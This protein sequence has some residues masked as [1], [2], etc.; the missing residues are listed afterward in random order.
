MK[1]CWK[2]PLLFVMF[3]L[4][5]S[6]TAA[7]VDLDTDTRLM[8]Y[9]EREAGVLPDVSLMGGVGDEL[10]GFEAAL[11]A[12]LK[13]F[14]QEV[15]AGERQ[16]TEIKLKISE[17]GDYSLVKE[18][19][20]EKL[21]KVHMCL[22]A[23]CP[24]DLYWH[25][26]YHTPVS[27]N[28]VVLSGKVVEM[29]VRFPVSPVYKVSDY[30]VRNDLAEL[31]AT[32][33]ETARGI[34]NAN[35]VKKDYEKLEAYKDAI[36]EMVSYD[37][38][39][40][41]AGEL[42]NAFDGNPDTNIACEGYSKA[43]KYLC[44]L[45]TFR[46]PGFAS[47]LVSGKTSASG[48]HM[49]NHV[50]LGGRN[51]LT[52][53]T[54]CDSNG[55]KNGNYSAYFMAHAL[56]EHN[57]PQ[58]GYTIQRNNPDKP[59]DTYV[60]TDIDYLNMYDKS[61][62]LLTL[63]TAPYALPEENIIASGSC[64]AKGDNVTYALDNLGVLLISGSGDMANYTADSPAPWEEYKGRIGS[65][66][67]ESGVTSIG[68]YAFQGCSAS[69]VNIP[70]SVKR[71]GYVA[72][73]QSSLTAVDMPEGV[74]TIADYAFQ[75]CGYL[76]S[77]KIPK[78]VTSIGKQAFYGDAALQSITIPE[79]VSI[80]SDYAFYKCGSLS[81]VTLPDSVINIGYAAFYDC[82]SLKSVSLPGKLTTISDYAFCKCAG[83]EAVTMPDTIISIGIQAFSGCSCLESIVIPSGV[84]VIQDKT[85]YECVSLTEIT[86]SDSIAGIG[87][88][89]FYGCASLSD[90]TMS[91]NAAIIGKCAFYKCSSLKRI[92]IPNGVTAIRDY[93]FRECAALTE[94]TMG[95]NV[96]EIGYAAFY[97]CSKLATVHYGGT[98]AQWEQLKAAK[99][100]FNAPLDSVR[101]DFQS[102]VTVSGVLVSGNA[103]KATVK[104][105]DGNAS[106][107]CG[108]FSDSG[109]MIAVRCAQVTGEVNYQFRFDEQ[110]FDYARVF[111]LANDFRPMC[112][113]VRGT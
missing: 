48:A 24:Y 9:L 85:F 69:A 52:D 92:T 43:L 73:Y 1:Y 5:L 12:K 64:G 100:E 14:V 60:L 50:T 59:S 108:V 79:G 87:D 26:F 71:V 27:G 4:A 7:A 94:I 88:Y 105:A 15:A 78:S 53:V 49:W 3:A 89:A 104:G 18:E 21:K 76:S 16:S 28:E 36:C 113:A 80:L 107:F 17:L 75:E 58:T 20:P 25:D 84:S 30:Q 54:W 81:G 2:C 110:R 6:L 63:S 23:D 11:Y 41:S 44:D 37:N 10:T 72:F 31:L 112:E 74:T 103:V 22:K 56:E 32:V 40:S 8:C 77:V 93:T 19:I 38:E 83:L 67:I 35:T 68:N 82:H 47:Y 65:V 51:Y 13:A 55:T 109:K 39:N 86:L 99:G 34:V 61:A 97:A 70:A 66:W 29:I 57:T 46:D 45:S 90:V 102:G 96:A 101:V 106:V 62:S 42:I 98:P 111:V 95:G 91:E 33:R